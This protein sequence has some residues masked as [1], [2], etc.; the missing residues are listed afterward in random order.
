MVSL[1]QMRSFFEKARCWLLA[2]SGCIFFQENV[3]SRRDGGVLFRRGFHVEG[4]ARVGDGIGCGVAEGAE[5]HLALL[6]IGEVLLQRLDS[7]R[8]EEDDHVVFRDID[9]VFEVVGNVLEEDGL[10]V[11]D[12]VLVAES[13]QAGGGHVAAARDEELALLVLE[14]E[15]KKALWVIVLVEED[16]ALAELDVVLEIECCRVGGTD[17]FH[18]LGKFDAQFLQEVEEVVN[19][20]FAGKYNRRMVKDIDLGLPE[21]AGSKRFYTEK[22]VKINVNTVFPLQF[23]VWGFVEI[24]W[25]ILGNQDVFNL[26]CAKTLMVFILEN[27]HLSKR[28][29]HF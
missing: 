19:R 7:R 21:L 20:V 26:H 1:E 27:P 15:V 2:S 17:V 22:F 4:E 28:C 23:R 6:E 8:A 9:L 12:V 24:G 14:N 13:G 11:G 29:K 10:C 18:V 5:C 25:G 16:L 3:H